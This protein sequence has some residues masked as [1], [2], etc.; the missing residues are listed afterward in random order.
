MSH[1]RQLGI[2]VN[3]VNA[4]QMYLLFGTVITSWAVNWPKLQE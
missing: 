4:E 2:Y 3:Q 1:V